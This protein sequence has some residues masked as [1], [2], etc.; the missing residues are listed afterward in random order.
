MTRRFFTGF[1]MLCAV[2][3]AGAQEPFPERELKPF[4]PK[5]RET[6]S[7]LDRSVRS[8]AEALADSARVVWDIG[9]FLNR[10]KTPS[11]GP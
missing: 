6:F 9:G 3:M 2:F 1:L 5:I 10:K 8:S 11:K 7:A 4:P